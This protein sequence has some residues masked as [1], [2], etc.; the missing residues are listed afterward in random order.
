MSKELVVSRIQAHPGAVTL[1][2]M[3]DVIAGAHDKVGPAETANIR[4]FLQDALQG[5]N[6][7]SISGGSGVMAGINRDKARAFAQQWLNTHPNNMLQTGG[8]LMHG[9]DT[10]QMAQDMVVYPYSGAAI[11]A[12]AAGAAM[13]G[14]YYGGLV[15]TLGGPIGIG[16]GLVVGAVVGYAAGSLY[17][18]FGAGETDPD[19]E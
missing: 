5:A 9:R 1:E 3:K 15:G 16:A 17:A 19:K 13:A 4:M 14:A 11:G 18:L 10:M 6:G 12:V 8:T 7:H 2:D